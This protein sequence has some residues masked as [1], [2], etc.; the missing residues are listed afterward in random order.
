MSWLFSQALAEEFSAETSLAGEQFAQL[1]RMPVVKGG[2]LELT[3][4]EMEAA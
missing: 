3:I 1:K 4:T 2:R